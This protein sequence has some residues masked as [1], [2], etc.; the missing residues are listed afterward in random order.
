LVATGNPWEPYRLVDGS[1]SVVGPAS[2][3]FAELQ[4]NGRA[5]STLHAYGNGLLRWWR[6]LAAVD[7][8]WDRATQV[9]ARDFARWLSIADKPVR[10]H[11]RHRQNGSPGDRILVVPGAAV[12]NPITG[13]ASPGA[14]YA[15]RTRA[16][17]E[18]VL[19]VFYDFHLEAGRGPI[20]NPF[21]L[22]RTRRGGRANAHHNPMERFKNERKGRYRPS[23][24]KRI[25]KRI[26]DEHFNQ[27][28]AGLKHHRDRALL[29]FWISTA[30]RAEE[31]LT[32]PQNRVT[33]GEQLIG[34]IR[35]GS[36]EL[37][38]L[39]ASPDSFVWLRLYQQEMWVRGCPR[40]GHQPLWFTLRRPWRPL[41]YPAAR[42]MFMRA[43]ELLG[44]NWTL[45]DLRH[46][47]AYRMAQD[48]QMPLTDVQWVLGHAHLTTTQIYT[49]PGPEDV[50]ARALAHHQRRGSAEAPADVP[51]EA[52][53]NP[54]SLDVLFGSRS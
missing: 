49:T 39:P 11:W 27:I 3:F 37:Q 6:F 12:V 4:A 16:H 53:Y 32:V 52:A 40:G 1:G 13:K 45:H 14:K 22:D 47:G 44:S 31:L 43:Q 50:V 10:I 48:P 46:T 54:K 41:A 8:V 21:P 34:V 26:P 33:P 35:K 30:A 15:A 36:Q 51:G 24:P 7:V 17:N 19:R 18:T 25:P 9:E 28:F 20:V 42:A 5:L 29:A 2:L 38:F 23:V